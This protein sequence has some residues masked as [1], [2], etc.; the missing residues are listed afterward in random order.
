VEAVHLHHRAGRLG[1]DHQHRA[2]RG[3]GDGQTE[4]EQN[5]E[6]PAPQG[7]TD[8]GPAEGGFAQPLDGR[9]EVGSEVG[10]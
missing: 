3:A 9:G 8:G 6:G 2:Q 10:E 5:G 1:F 7:Q 4:G